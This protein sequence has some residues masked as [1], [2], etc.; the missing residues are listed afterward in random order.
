MKE[1]GGIRK[2]LELLDSFFSSRNIEFWLEAGTALA[3]YRDGKVFAWEHDID[4]AIWREKVPDLDELTNFFHDE[5]FDVIIQKS[6]PFLDNIIQL[7]V[8]DREKS[9]VFDIDIYLYS[10]QNNYAYMRW[11]QKPEGFFGPLKKNIL[12]LLRN[13][14]NP[15]NDKW[16]RRSKYFP[17]TLINKF[18]RIYLNVYVYFSSCI[19]HRFPVEY[20]DK[21]KN[22]NFYGIEVKIPYHTEKFLIHRYGENWRTPDSKFNQS[23]KW[24]KSGARVLLPMRLLPTPIFDVN[25]VKSK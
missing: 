2:S 25:L 21:L 4:V 11:I 19:Y 13:I 20:F 10:R 6:L 16:I 14:I 22:I 24:K 18:F 5:N 17:R 23:G 8:K 9:N 7:K 1:I 12:F 3:A 15:K